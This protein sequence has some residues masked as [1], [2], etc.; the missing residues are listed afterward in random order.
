MPEPYWK[1]EEAGLYLYHGDMRDI[2]PALTLQADLLV[3][4][5][6]YGE[7]S[8]A[9]D[10]WPDGWPTLAATVT[11]SMWCFGSMRMFLQ[12]AT[13]L[14]AA[15]WRLSQDVVWE[16]ANGTGFAAD[17]FKRVH[18]IATHWYRGD[19]KALHHDTP[20]VAYTGPSKHVRIRRDDRAAHTGSVKAVAYHDDDTRLMRSVL[21][22]Q[23]VRGGLH[24]TEKPLG[25]L[26]PLIRYACPPGGLVIDPFA[27]SGSTLDAARQ[28]GRH[29]I[30]IEA[31]ERYAEAAARR[32]SAATLPIS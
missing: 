30:G 24:P 28:T 19:W 8:L 29:A 31:D 25:I 22:A 13:E 5:P 20:K 23:S 6:P 3:V 16:K 10:R 12:R 17:R 32:L 2:L 27:G 7:T 21:R 4:D 26:D 14:Q 11:R 15:G 18:E 9:W 1:D